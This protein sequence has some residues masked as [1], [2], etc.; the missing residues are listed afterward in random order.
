MVRTIF[1]LLWPGAALASPVAAVV[2]FW[3]GKSVLGLMGAA[4]LPTAAIPAM[5]EE[6]AEQIAALVFDQ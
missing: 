6:A 2:C 4:T 5:Q 1:W 3:K